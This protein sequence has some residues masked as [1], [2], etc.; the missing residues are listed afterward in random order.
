VTWSG[1]LILKISKY[2][3]SDGG[4]P[5][6]AGSYD[7][8]ETVT[9][10]P[11]RYRCQY[12]VAIVWHNQVQHSARPASECVCRVLPGKMVAEEGDDGKH[13]TTAICIWFMR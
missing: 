4:E 12:P 13:N 6:V 2:S 10:Q 3:V 5:G 7:M 8:E 9:E 1:I 11:D